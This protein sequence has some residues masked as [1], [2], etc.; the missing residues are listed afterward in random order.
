MKIF[1]S[2]SMIACLLGSFVQAEEANIDEQL[3][4][5]YDIKAEEVSNA[6]L[7]ELGF[8]L[9]KQMKEAGPDAAVEVCSDLAP[10]IVNR[11]S[12]EKGWRVTR[13]G[14]RARNPLLGMADDW[15]QS[16]FEIFE[17]RKRAGESLKDQHYSEISREKSGTYYR[18][19]K[20][21]AVMPICT[22]C[23]GDANSVPKAVLTNYPNDLAT[24]YHAGDL[25]GAV[26]IKIPLNNN[27][28]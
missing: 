18:Y 25:R 27:E 21:L 22:T 15:E 14:T 11:I 6:L 2:I 8:A 26:S 20:A 16:A 7:K 17:Q 5:Q 12:L 3:I 4:S 19:A 10:K 13:V 28:Q 24:G 9:K 23:H 1:L